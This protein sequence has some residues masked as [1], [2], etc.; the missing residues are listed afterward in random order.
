MLPYKGERGRGARK[1]NM[2]KRSQRRRDLK[3]NDLEKKKKIRVGTNR[4]SLERAL[5]ALPVGRHQPWEIHQLI[6]AIGC[7]KD[8]G[9]S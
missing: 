4:K 7:V 9:F 6:E 1:N 8:N 3:S 5:G 2:A